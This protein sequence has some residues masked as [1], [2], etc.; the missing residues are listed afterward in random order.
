MLKPYNLN[1]ETTEQV[2]NEIWVDIY[3]AQQNDTILNG[4][5]TGIEEHNVG[6]EVGKALALVV[7]FDHVKG[8]IPQQECGIYR[9]PTDEKGKKKVVLNKQERAIVKNQ[10]KSLVGMTEPVKIVD[11]HREDDIVILS[12]EKALEHL[13]KITWPKLS[14]NKIITAKVRSV[15][16]RRVIL[17]IGGIAVP[18][19]SEELSWGFINEPKMLVTPGDEL[20]VKIMELDKEKESIK[21][22][23]RETIPNP[24]PECVKK[25]KKNN[26]Y[27]GKVTG[28][29]EQAVFVNL[30]PGVDVYCKHLAFERVRPGD[31]SVVKIT[32]I[33]LESKRVWGNLVGSRNR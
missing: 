30:E 13:A 33:D 7:M 16:R 5:I 22:S 29:I 31:R 19:A 1:L 12:R 15:G 24:W 8:I 4:F 28:V 6:G 21:V 20:N 18:M 25:Y 14:A 26:L 3:A 10:L 2:N 27:M 11:I 32:G 9:Y 17:D 23:H